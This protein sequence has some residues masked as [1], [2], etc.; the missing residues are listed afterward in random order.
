MLGLGDQIG[1]AEDGVCGSVSEDDGL[2]RSEYAIDVDLT[3]NHPFG[4]S[5]EDVARAADLVDLADGLSTVG[6]GADGGDAADLVYRVHTGDA[7]GSENCG[8]QRFLTSTGRSQY[9]LGHTGNAGR[10]GS[11]Q[12]GGGIGGGA[13]GSVQP[14]PLQRPYQLTEAAAQV[15]PIAGQSRLVEFCDPAGGQLEGP[16]QVIGRGLPRSLFQF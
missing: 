7:S 14:H 16:L 12:D 11:H 15:H 1:S 6:E 9:H 10:D 5:D 4:V 8:I 3:L 13:A 2:G